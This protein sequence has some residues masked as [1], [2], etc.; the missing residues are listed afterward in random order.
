MMA[1][2]NEGFTKDSA[3]ED[4]GRHE[5]PELSAVVKNTNG[6]TNGHAN[7]HANPS[8]ENETSKM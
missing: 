7:G 4:K 1:F 8:I 3:I 2:E 5:T 6:H